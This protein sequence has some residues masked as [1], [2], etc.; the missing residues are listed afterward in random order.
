MADQHPDVI[1]FREF[2]EGM[3]AVLEEVLSRFEAR[4]G[5]SFRLVDE[6]LALES[7]TKDDAMRL[8]ENVPNTYVTYSRFFE[9]IPDGRWLRPLRKRGLFKKPTGPE[10]Y[11]D[12]AFR[13]VPWPPSRYL[14]RVVGLEPDLVKEII[15]E[16]PAT[17][18]VRVHE[19]IAAAARKMPPALAAH[20]VSKATAGLDST[21]R[22]S[23]LPLELAEVVA[24]LARGGRGE[25]AVALARELLA[26]VPETTTPATDLGVGAVWPARVEAVPRFRQ[27]EDYDE[28]VDACLSPLVDAAG[29]RAFGM[30]CDLLEDAI[31]ISHKPYRGDGDEGLPYRD[32]LYVLRP[33]IEDSIQNDVC[34]RLGKGAVY[35]LVSAVR[36]AAERIAEADS[37]AVAR[38]VAALEGKKNETFDRLALHL[39]RSFADAPSASGMVAARLKMKLA[40]L[41]PGLFHEYAALLGECYE[42]LSLED[43]REILKA[44]GEGPPPGELE[45]AREHRASG[46]LSGDTPSEE[47]IEAYVRGFAERWRLRRYAVLADLLPD[48]ERA[49]YERLAGEHPDLVERAPLFYNDPRA[50]PIPQRGSPKSARDLLAISVEEAVAFLCD[51][52]PANDWEGPGVRDVA[53]ELRL[54]VAEAP[55]RFAA[56]AE[57]FRRLDP[58]YVSALIWGLR[59]VLRNKGG[60]RDAGDAEKAP[61]AAPAQG[62]SFEWGPVLGL[63]RWVLDQP[64]GASEEK[65][66]GGRDLGWGLSRRWIAWLLRDALRQQG[67]IA[68]GLREEVWGV[69]RDLSEDPE[70]ALDDEEDTANRPGSAPRHLVINTVRGVAMDAVVAYALWVRLNVGDGSWC[71]LADA[72]EAREVL[73]RRLDPA[74]EP[75]RT[76]RSVYGSAL[77]LLVYL[78]RD[79][80]E[81]QLPR[82][83]PEDEATQPLRDATWESYLL[84]WEASY[85][86]VFEVLR[87]QYAAAVR[88]LD[89][90]RVPESSRDPDGS[91]AEHLM[92][93]LWRGTLY[94]G[95]ADGIL[96]NFYAR[97][98]D[99]LRRR[100]SPR[101][102]T[103]SRHLTDAV[104]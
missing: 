4:F 55:A 58:S 62:P 90:R 9:G 36:D 3:Q 15:L 50:V 34:A 71:G 30:L 44:I 76:V 51:F 57:R 26:L 33:S 95:E 14:A 10:T 2:F 56:E 69:L 23:V 43:R 65:Y 20:V 96:E 54:A 77:P 75:T 13:H 91:L 42:S 31:R 64:R 39:L 99:P 79:W 83:F 66:S 86:D 27:P 17:D 35:R 11:E 21:S 85:D 103:S 74:V 72:V 46:S 97:A 73:E 63:S 67:E 18:N 52:E 68:F 7:P 88:C 82:I 89:P 22:A 24:Y 40:E 93:L 1:E 48:A 102:P 81:R 70:P 47:K 28:V 94:F 12:G 38:I 78:D 5:S 53:E 98:S 61:E 100:G 104:E 84:D 25:E 16:L 87:P 80:V 60:A 19:D 32:G 49:E 59:D 101:K 41:T 92:T 6:L 45:A 37:S 29:E 8:K